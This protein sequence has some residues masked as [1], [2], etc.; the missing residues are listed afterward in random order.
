MTQYA[1]KKGV[2]LFQHAS[3]KASEPGGAQAPTAGAQVIAMSDF[4]RPP[5]APV[6]SDALE[7]VPSIKAILRWDYESL[8]RHMGASGASTDEIALTLDAVRADLRTELSRV[9]SHKQ[10]QIAELRKRQIGQAGLSPILAKQWDEMA[11]RLERQCEAAERERERASVGGGIVAP[12][13]AKLR[14]GFQRGCREAALALEDLRG[15]K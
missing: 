8:G 13:E 1:L 14:L 11:N 7:D 9:I 2:E 5:A 12:C 15:A 6:R 10:G 3:K 4:Q